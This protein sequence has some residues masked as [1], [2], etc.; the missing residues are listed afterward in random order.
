M[1]RLHRDIAAALRA[2]DLAAALRAQGFDI[3]ATTPAQYTA[4]ITSDLQ[5][6][7]ELARATG[8]KIG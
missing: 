5:R 8:I 3:E 7:G 6:W 1:D 2:P 4:K